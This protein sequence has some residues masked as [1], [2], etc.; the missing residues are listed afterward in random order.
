M[1]RTLAAAL[2]LAALFALQ[3]ARAGGDGYVKQAVA[4]PAIPR[5]LYLQSEKLN[6]YAGFVMPLPASGSPRGY[7]LRVLTDGGVPALTDLDA[8]FYTDIEGTGRPC[9]RDATATAGGGETGSL[10]AGATHA[11]VVLFT[12][13][14]VTFDLTLHPAQG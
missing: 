5:A 7:T 3:P 14:D 1:K 11:V 12:G 9:P 10:C 8:W 4:H 6:G 2:A 13:A